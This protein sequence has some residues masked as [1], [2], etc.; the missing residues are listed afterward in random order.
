MIIAG[1]YVVLWGKAK[2]KSELDTDTEKNGLENDSN[3]NIT[4]TAPEESTIDINQP[5]L[6]HDGS[7][8]HLNHSNTQITRE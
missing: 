8:E 5:L 2:D 7:A 3:N 4:I 1:L 6:Q